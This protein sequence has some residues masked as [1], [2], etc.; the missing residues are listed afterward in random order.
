MHQD[1]KETKDKIF[2][3]SDRDNNCHRSAR[4]KS[5]SQ[6]DAERNSE[7][8]NAENELKCKLC[9]EVLEDNDDIKEHYINQHMAHLKLVRGCSQ[10]C[11]VEYCMEIQ[12]DSCSQFCFFYKNLLLFAEKET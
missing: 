9:D 5:R 7:S 12:E 11:E 8:K 3:Q 10:Q 6:A 2:F 4:S 1:T